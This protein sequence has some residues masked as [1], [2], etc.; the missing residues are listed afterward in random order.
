MVDPTGQ[1]VGQYYARLLAYY[2][3]GGFTDENG[4]F[5]KSNY[6]YNLTH[7]EVLV[8]KNNLS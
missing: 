5:I 3:K 7:W 2:T 8:N 4:I 1:T 6:H